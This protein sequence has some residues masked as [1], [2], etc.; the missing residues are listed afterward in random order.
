MSEQ[1]QLVQLNQT[2]Q[3]LGISPQSIS[4]DNR[5]ALLKSANDP[6]ALLNLVH[7]LGVID[8]Q[9]RSLGANNLSSPAQAATQLQ[10]AAPAQSQALSQSQVPTLSP[11]SSSPAGSGF[12]TSLEASTVPSP[13]TQQTTAAGN[14][15][16]QFQELQLAFQATDLLQTPPANPGSS[17]PQAPSLNVQA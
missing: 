16:A 14:P 17:G 7:A 10:A 1:E 6:P 2:L 3:R 15:A 5:L 4:L 11:N 13:S 12:E 9:A 8:P